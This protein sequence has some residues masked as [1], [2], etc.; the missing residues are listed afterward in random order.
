MQKLCPRCGSNGSQKKFIGLFCKDCYAERLDVGIERTVTIEVCKWCGRLRQGRDWVLLNRQTLEK[1]LKRAVHGDYDSIR[2]VVPDGAEG[3]SQAVFLVEVGD[4]FIEKVR[5]F[6]LV[7][8]STICD[9]DSRTSS[10]YFEAIIQVRCETIEKSKRLAEKIKREICRN[11]FITKFEEDK[12][13]I[14][15]YAG[16]NKAVMVALE[17]MGVHS[18]KSATLYGVK[19]GQRVYRTTYCVRG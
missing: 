8:Q 12:H 11:T 5:Q 19:D 15:I 4:E 3:D 1:Q 14:D 9:D 13:G 6:V 7:R 18:Q 10:G 17:K 2:F 16:S